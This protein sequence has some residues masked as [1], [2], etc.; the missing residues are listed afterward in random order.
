MLSN[1]TNCVCKY[2]S[3]GYQSIGGAWA[4]NF[5]CYVP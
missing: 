4:N 1:G 5:A 2:L 3:N